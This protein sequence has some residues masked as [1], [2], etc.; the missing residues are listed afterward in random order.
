MQSLWGAGP[1]FRLFC[2]SP[3]LGVL[4]WFLCNIWGCKRKIKQSQQWLESSLKQRQ[5]ATDEV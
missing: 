4:P 2:C 5:E 3:G 1:S